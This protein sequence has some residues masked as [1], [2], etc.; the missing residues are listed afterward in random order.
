M[1]SPYLSIPAECHDA[2]PDPYWLPRGSESTFDRVSLLAQFDCGRFLVCT[3]R[4]SDNEMSLGSMAIKLRG[5]DL[6]VKDN[7]LRGDSSLLHFI[8]E[9]CTNGVSQA[10]C[11]IHISKYVRR[12]EM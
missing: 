8:A 2:G 6:P 7:I 3:L 12:T 1:Y 11:R 5:E 9:S 4:S 10:I